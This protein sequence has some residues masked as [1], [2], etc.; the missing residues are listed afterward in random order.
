MMRSYTGQRCDTESH[1]LFWATEKVILTMIAKQNVYKN[2]KS[3]SKNKHIW[4]LDV[5]FCW[6]SKKIRLI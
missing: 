4:V 2:K 6:L 3:K 1:S 5:G